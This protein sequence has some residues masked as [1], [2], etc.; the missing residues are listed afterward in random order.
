VLHT[1]IMHP[2]K[3]TISFRAHIRSKLEVN[4]YGTVIVFVVLL[5]FHSTIQGLFSL[6][7]PRVETRKSES[8][9]KTIFLNVR[10]NY[11]KENLMLYSKCVVTIKGFF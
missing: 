11:L 6:T 3:F 4:C 1:K 10:F 7:H 9:E 5:E 8:S 2:N